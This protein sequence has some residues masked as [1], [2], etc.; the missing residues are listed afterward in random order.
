MEPQARGAEATPLL[1]KRDDKQGWFSGVGLLTTRR[2]DASGASRGA[3]AVLALG[4][5]TMLCVGAASTSAGHG[6]LS[7]L[8]ASSSAAAESVDLTPLGG[9]PAVAVGQLGDDPAFKLPENIVKYPTPLPDVN[10]SDKTLLIVMGH[11]FSGTSALEGLIGTGNGV[12]DLCDSG[13]WQ[14]EDTWL[15]KYMNFD[16]EPG[17][18]EWDDSYP[19]DAAGYA[20]AFKH[21]AQTWWDMSK[22][23]L[24]DKTPNLLAHYRTVVGA[25]EKLGVPVKF[26]LLTRHPFSWTSETHP[27]NQGLW[28]QLMQY[29]LKVLND[30]SIEVH[31]IKYEDLAWN[32]DETIKSLQAFL[33]QLGELDPWGSALEEPKDAEAKEINGDRAMGIAQ[34]FQREP[35]DWRPLPLDDETFKMLCAV[36]YNNDG[37]CNY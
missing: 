13:T 26:V 5:A 19:V 8:G 21:F 9:S 22:P 6:V 37:E 16:I 17:V 27:F 24:M 30:P 25:A 14:C 18:D 32:L 2:D 31:Q 34:Y 23:L 11:P 29:S 15:L 4:A 28:M 36:G 20:Y 3:R 10:F 33:P 1:R 12:T 35:L 7:S